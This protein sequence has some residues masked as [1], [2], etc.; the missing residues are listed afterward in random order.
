M[1]LDRLARIDG[2]M[3]VSVEGASSTTL[4]VVGGPPTVVPSSKD[5]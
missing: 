1:R 4:S 5:V 2:P 3:T